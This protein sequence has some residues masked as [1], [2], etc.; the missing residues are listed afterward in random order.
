MHAVAAQERRAL[1]HAVQ[2][3]PVVGLTISMGTAKSTVSQRS[4]VLMLQGR[5]GWSLVED[6]DVGLFQ[7]CRGRD[8]KQPLP[9]ARHCADARSRSPA[10]R[11]SRPAHVDTPPVVAQPTFSSEPC[12]TSRTHG[13]SARPGGTT[14]GTLPTRRP[15][16]RMTLPPFSSS[17]PVR[18]FSKVDLPVPFSPTSAVARRRAGTT[19]RR[20]RGP[21][22]EE[23]GPLHSE[24]GLTRRH[25]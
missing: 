18:H 23:R 8:Q 14:C 6:Q 10:R 20:T 22:R 5:D 16:E 2:E 13:R 12:R 21:S 3:H 17:S 9:A 4:S 15:R 11:R 24:H 19:R 7:P 25:G 1:G